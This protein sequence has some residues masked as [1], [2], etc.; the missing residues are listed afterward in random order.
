MEERQRQ[1][2]N[3]GFHLNKINLD[4]R[5]DALEPYQEWVS[6]ILCLSY[7]WDSH[8]NRIFYNVQAHMR[9]IGKWPH[10]NQMDLL[11]KSQVGPPKH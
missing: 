4:G 9:I 2:I 5:T 6:N 3:T 8:V 11:D 1:T 7:R 10:L